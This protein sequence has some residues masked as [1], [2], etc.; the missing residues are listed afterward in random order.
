MVGAKAVTSLMTGTVTLRTRGG[1]SGED[2]YGEPIYDPPQDVEC[3]AWIEP[4]SSGEN[5]AAREQYVFGYTLYLPLDADL[6]GADVVVVYGE[7]HNVIG[8]PGKQMGGF[9]VEGYQVAAVE[10]VTG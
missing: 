10:R 4:R 8:Q 1:V 6:D 3:P 5:V 2:R 9:I 7:E